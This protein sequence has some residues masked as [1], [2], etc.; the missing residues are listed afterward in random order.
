[1]D[2]ADISKTCMD[3]AKKYGYVLLILGIGIILMLL[4]GSDKQ[5]E[6]GSPPTSPSQETQSMQDALEGILSQIQG[7]GKVRV[8]L[9]IAEGEMTVYEKDEDSVSGTE[10]GSLKVETVIIT[11]ESRAQQPVVQQVNPPVYMGAVVVCQ[12]ADSAQVRL[13][14]TEAVAAATGLTADKITVLKMK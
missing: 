1:M 5:E 8:L 14:I 11:D 4:P 10:T 13:A 6:A 12:G 3:F 9:T 7:A 2:R